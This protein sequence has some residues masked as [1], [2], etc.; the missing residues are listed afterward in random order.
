MTMALRSN[1]GGCV[2]L[3]MYA[4][5]PPRKLAVS[6]PE[7]VMNETPRPDAPVLAPVAYRWDGDTQILTAT[8]GRRAPG[9]AADAMVEIVG[10]DGSWLNIDLCGGRVQFVEIAV[11]PSV[12]DVPVLSVPSCGEGS[13]PRFD[14]AN[15]CA[16]VRSLEIETPVIA[17]ADAPRSTFH[18]RFGAFGHSKS[19]RLARDLVADLDERG[20]LAGLW[21]TNVPPLSPSADS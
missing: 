8:V 18:F 4:P 3:G 19:V 5:V 1:D 6:L 9:A 10:R 13:G 14:F 17:E 21:L 7:S 12:R 20:R 11:W 15:S 2:R 16:G